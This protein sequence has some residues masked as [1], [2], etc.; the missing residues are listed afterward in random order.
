MTTHAA[1][2]QQGHR[3]DYGGRPVLALGSGHVAIVAE[4]HEEKPWALG[5]EHTVKASW[6]TPLPMRYF[7]GQVPA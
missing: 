3:Y 6:L 4:I 1:Q 2:V 7:H 5:Q